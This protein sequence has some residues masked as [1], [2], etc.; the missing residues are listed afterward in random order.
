[1]RIVSNLIH[2]SDRLYGSMAGILARLYR[3]WLLWLSAIG[4]RFTNHSVR[5]RDFKAQ[6]DIC[7]SIEIE[8]KGF[9]LNTGLQTLILILIL[10]TNYSYRDNCMINRTVPCQ[11]CTEDKCILM[12]SSHVFLLCYLLAIRIKYILWADLQAKT[13]SSCAYYVMMRS[14]PVRE[15]LQLS[16]RST[17][18]GFLTFFC[19]AALIGAIG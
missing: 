12:N 16:I 4:L 2:A 13:L 5:T 6:S 15:P 14:S 18:Q 9:D 3:P 11:H 8:P 1:M 19:V 7:Y 17:G 10:N